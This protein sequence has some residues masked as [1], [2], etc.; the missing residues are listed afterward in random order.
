MRE[1]SFSYRKQTNKAPTYHLEQII[2]YMK[3]L[4][5]SRG[6]L[7]YESKNSHEL[8]IIPVEVNDNYIEW[9][10]NAFEWMREVR[11]AWEDE[12]L[13]MKPYRSN[14]KVCKG[15]PV[16]ETCFAGPKGDIKIEPL[17]AL[18]T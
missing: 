12:Q 4:K 10:D 3:I 16:K 2:I 9:V 11:K 13:P 6:V 7:I 1:E 5:K 18:K 15:C 14:S 8:H 17:K